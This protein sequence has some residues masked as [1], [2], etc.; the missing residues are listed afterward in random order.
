MDKELGEKHSAGASLEEK[1]S[2]EEELSFQ[3]GLEPAVHKPSVCKGHCVNE[4][5]ALGPWVGLH[6][7]PMGAFTVAQLSGPMM[8]EGGMEQTADIPSASQETHQGQRLG[9]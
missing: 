8:E 9:Q 5:R 4:S 3:T 1:R 2:E 7:H 6:L